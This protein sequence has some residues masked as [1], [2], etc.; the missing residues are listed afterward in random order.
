[1]IFNTKKQ[2]IKRL[3]ILYLKLLRPTEMAQEINIHEEQPSP[4]K[5]LKEHANIIENHKQM[6]SGKLVINGTILSEILYLGQEDGG[7][8]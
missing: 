4:V 6:A 5:I 1:M 3:P 8:K 2:L 7:A